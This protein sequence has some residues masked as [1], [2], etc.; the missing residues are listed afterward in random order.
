MTAG[1]ATAAESNQRYK[2]LIEVG[3]TYV[4]TAMDLP[5]HM[6]LDSDH[7]LAAGEVGKTGIPFCTAKDMLDLFKDVPIEKLKILGCHTNVIA[8]L[9]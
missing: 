9:H 1:Y 3:T 8:I 7:P 5:T 4:N 6:G 2:R